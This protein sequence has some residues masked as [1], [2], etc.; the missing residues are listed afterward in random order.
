MLEDFVEFVFS[1]L[2]GLGLLVVVVLL[3]RRNMIKE[4]KRQE[5]LEASE[6]GAKE[7][8]GQAGTPDQS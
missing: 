2:L 1:A 3:A 4:M 8:Q 7:S 5:E 6:K